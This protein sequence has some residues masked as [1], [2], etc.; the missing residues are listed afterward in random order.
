MCSFIPGG[1][2]KTTPHLDIFLSISPIF[3]R[4]HPF[5]E[6]CNILVKCH[7]RCNIQVRL[8]YYNIFDKDA[9]L[10]VIQDRFKN[11]TYA[12]IQSDSKNI[13]SESQNWSENGS[14]I[15]HFWDGSSK[16]SLCANV[17]NDGSF[18]SQ[19][20]PKNGATSHFG[21]FFR[22]HVFLNPQAGVFGS[23]NPQKAHK[24]IMDPNGSESFLYC[25][26]VGSSWIVPPPAVATTFCG[27][28]NAQRMH[29]TS[30]TSDI[31]SMM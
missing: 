2:L 1:A 9:Q 12:I 21:Q 11:V 23:K 26:Y 27:G 31:T 6:K 29:R 28:P 17:M 24:N 30:T 10:C 14:E 3:V 22:K 15:L 13:L 7:K 25:S 8:K 16:A 18:L 4:F 5:F 19:N 20:A